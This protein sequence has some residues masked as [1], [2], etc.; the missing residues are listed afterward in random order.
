MMAEEDEIMKEKQHQIMVLIIASSNAQLE[1]VFVSWNE[2]LNLETMGLLFIF[3]KESMA[4][5]LK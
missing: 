3:H 4:H 5:F 2:T 1:V